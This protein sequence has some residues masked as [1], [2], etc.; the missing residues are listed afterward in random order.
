[1]LD[2][3]LSVDVDGAAELRRAARRTVVSGTCGCGC[4]SIDFRPGTG[5]RVMVNATVAGSFDSL[6]LYLIDGEL[7][8]IEWVGVSDDR[9]TELPEPARLTITPA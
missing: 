1:M 6:F 9:P 8:G 2:T 3:L 5:M 4:P 7:G